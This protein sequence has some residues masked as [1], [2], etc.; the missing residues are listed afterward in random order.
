MFELFELK[1]LFRG[2]LFLCAVVAFV[3][4][5]IVLTVVYTYN[6]EYEPEPEVRGKCEKIAEN[7]YRCSPVFEEEKP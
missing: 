7:Y 4:S 6:K 3:T 2:V 1:F 5:I